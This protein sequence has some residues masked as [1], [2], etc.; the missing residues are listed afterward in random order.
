[1]H[2]LM[3]VYQGADVSNE[4]GDVHDVVH[5]VQVL[6]VFPR[7]GRS[8]HGPSVVSVSTYMS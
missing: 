7:T 1:M 8:A 4:D 2:S 5:T 3:R 6:S